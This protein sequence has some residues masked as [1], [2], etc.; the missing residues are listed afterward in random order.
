M[1]AGQKAGYAT[2]CAGSMFYFAGEK[3]VR[4]PC[5]RSLFGVAHPSQRGNL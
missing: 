3:V 4:V 5:V 1:Y 2:T